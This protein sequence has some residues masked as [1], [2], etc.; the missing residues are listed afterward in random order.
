ML[1]ARAALADLKRDE[2]RVLLGLAAGFSY[3]EV[4][5]RLHFT[6]TKVN[7]CAAEGRSHLR[8]LA[9]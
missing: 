4:G 9:A 8:A 6:H 3:A 7:R 5:E 1:D 2:R